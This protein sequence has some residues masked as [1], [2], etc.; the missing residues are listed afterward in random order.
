MLCDSPGI[1]REETPDGENL[2]HR[3]T[4]RVAAER[5]AAVLRPPW[6]SPEILALSL[7]AIHNETSQCE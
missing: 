3:K 5:V 4:Q 7:D 1:L 6:H 2:K